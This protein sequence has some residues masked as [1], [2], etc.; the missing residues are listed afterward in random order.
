MAARGRRVW[1]LRLNLLCD[2]YC[3]LVFSWVIVG[4]TKRKEN[5]MD[6]TAE[7]SEVI[8]AH[9][10]LEFSSEFRETICAECGWAVAR[11][12]EGEDPV[13]NHT[14][15][16]AEV[17]APFIRQA[18]A[19]TLREAADIVMGPIEYLVDGAT[20]RTLAALIRE[21]ADQIEAN[22]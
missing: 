13:K 14:A 16:L 7:A 11:F 3:G 6:I 19:Q 12:G 22:A 2:L 18:Q 1:F 20:C 17:L 4:V 5:P 10:K 21:R 9:R 15:H 8:A